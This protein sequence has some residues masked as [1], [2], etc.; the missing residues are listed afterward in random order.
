L[1]L[2]KSLLDF[3]SV[4]FQLPLRLGIALSLISAV[5]VVIVVIVI[6]NVVLIVAKGFDSMSRHGARSLRTQSL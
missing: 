1:A 4:C 2:L 6:I 5:I 3:V